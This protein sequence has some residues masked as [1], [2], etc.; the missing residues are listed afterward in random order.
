MVCMVIEFHNKKW[1]AQNASRHMKKQLPVAT[2]ISEHPTM[3]MECGII[4]TFLYLRW[5]SPRTAQQFV[6]KASLFGQK[7]SPSQISYWRETRHM[8]ILLYSTAYPLG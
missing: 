7:S 8:K 6:A 5:T 4:G 3:T 1:I 2:Y